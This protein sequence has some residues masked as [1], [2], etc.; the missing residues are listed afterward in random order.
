[1][2]WKQG[3]GA[4]PSQWLGPQ[5]VV[6]HENEHTIWTTMASKLYRVA[7]EHVRPVTAH[8]ATQI[9]HEP[10]EPT[11]SQIAQHIPT[12]TR[13]G[14][15]QAID[16][17][18]TT[19]PPPVIPDATNS[20]PVPTPPTTNSD[21]EGQPDGE[22]MPPT[23][24]EE[25]RTDHQLPEPNNNN[26]QDLPNA[27][28][29]PVPSGDTD[30][31]L[32]C[33][34]LYCIDLDESPLYH[35]EHETCTEAWTC[36]VYVT[37]D[38]IL[39]WKNETDMSDMT[40][41]ATAA[42]RQRSEVKLSTLSEA[43]RREFQKA[44]ESEIQNWVKTGTISKILR[45]QIPHD[46]ILRCR[47]ILTW[48]PI[49]E[50]ER[51]K[52]KGTKNHKA[53]ARL[54]ILGYLDPELTELPRDSPTLG[55]NSKMLLLQMIASYGWSLRSFDIKAAFLQG[56]PQPGRVLGIEPV[57][58]MIH[59]LQLASN[60]ILKLEKGAYGLVD[61][62]YLW[63]TAILEELMH[64]GFEQSPFC[65]C[66]FILRNKVTN[67]PDGVLGLHVDDGIC[68][69]NQRFLDVI[70]QLEKKYPF[71]SKKLHQFTFT[72]IE[73]QQHPNKSIT[74]S[75]SK[76]VCAIKPI[77]ITNQRRSQ[78]DEPISEDE[79]Q[80]LRAVI[81]SLQYAAVHTRPDLASRLSNL[82]SSINKATVETLCF[83]N[84]TLHEAKKFHDVTI[85]IQSIPIDDLRFLA[86]SDASFASKT[87]P[88]SHTGS[89]IMSTHKDIQ[90]NVTCPVSPLS[91]GCKKIQRVVTSTLA[92]EA[93]SLST[94]LD[95]LSWIRLCWAWML[96]PNTNW[97][98][99][100]DTLR[101]LP[102]TVSTATFKAQNL[103][104]SITA[105]DCKSL[106]D[107]VTRTA[108]PNCQ[109]YRTQL[110]ARSIKDFLSENV[111]LRWVHSGAQLA[112]GLTKIMQNDFLRA[113]L[114]AGHYRLNDELE[115][116]KDRATARNR[117]RWLKSCKSDEAAPTCCNECFLSE[118]FEFL[119]V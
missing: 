40:F 28:A 79:R 14:T 42:K 37:E 51:I 94:V 76:Y 41:V 47:W 45:D 103:P 29:T 2:I 53:K 38:D 24:T 74:M 19:L 91:W 17:S 102:E 25:T 112:D 39:N 21:T 34:G 54:V 101:K 110:T 58:E 100:Q 97:K 43:E 7:P 118:S 49:D 63:Y 92:A 32:M 113:T 117:I 56:K 6:V 22:P 15:T 27:I 59:T 26:P 80:E 69:G 31:E 23:P 10:G 73:M 64:L 61:A 4:Y 33:D 86:F 107:L 60:E 67:R 85:T 83:A 12:E 95:Q 13:T 116:L 99:P 65:P 106:F 115:V 36:H 46:Q 81:G 93:T 50:E 109:E 82:Q 48:K 5:K 30:D 1:M 20:H 114:A 75:Q 71:G 9:V 87:N 105:T 52:I 78:Q 104:A 57:P 66:T 18:N 96:D 35:T 88:N 90:N 70:D 72:G 98:S 89:L 84:Q 68:G 62:P 108:V 111:V 8:E 3:K 77:R 11:I 44:K 55:R 119:G 16:L